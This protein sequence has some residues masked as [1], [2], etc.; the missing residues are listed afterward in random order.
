MYMQAERGTV[1]VKC[2]AQEHNMMFPARAWTRTAQSWVEYTKYKVKM[3]EGAKSYFGKVEASQHRN[4][5][6]MTVI[7]SLCTVYNKFVADLVM[8]CFCLL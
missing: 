3:T 1:R 4:C 6:T 5:F 2:L 7:V 8:L